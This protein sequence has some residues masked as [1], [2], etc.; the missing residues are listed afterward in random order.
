M[1]SPPGCG[2]LFAPHLCSVRHLHLRLPLSRLLVEETAP[3][4]PLCEVPLHPAHAPGPEGFGWRWRRRGRLG[5]RER[6]GRGW[7]LWSD[8]GRLR[9][10]LRSWPAPWALLLLP[11]TQGRPP[12]SLR[13]PFPLSS[14][15]KRK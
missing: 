11:R 13:L 14:F 1:A 2:A 9:P 15:R 5:M 12:S 8:G 10:F 4:L 6:W 7:E 3:P